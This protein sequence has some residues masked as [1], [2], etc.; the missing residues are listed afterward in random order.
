MKSIDPFIIFWTTMVLVIVAV[1]FAWAINDLNKGS[2]RFG[3]GWRGSE[4]VSREEEPFE[5]W[6]AV[7]S[8]FAAVPV[9]GFMIWF[10]LTS[11][12]Q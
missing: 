1:N 3:W 9:G 11:F 8:K 4:R 2:A 12:G 7:G 6:L 5:F 10:A